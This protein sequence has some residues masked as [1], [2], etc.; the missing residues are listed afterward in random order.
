MCVCFSCDRIPR[1][2]FSKIVGFRWY[3]IALVLADG[4]LMMAF[5]HLVVPDV[6]NHLVFLVGQEMEYRGTTAIHLC[7]EDQLAEDWV[8]R[9]SHDSP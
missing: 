9:V 2:C 4:V 8:G 1:G 5:S 3:H 6:G 7:L